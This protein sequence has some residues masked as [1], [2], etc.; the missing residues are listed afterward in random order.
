MWHRSS[1]DYL[2][3][4]NTNTECPVLLPHK[5]PGTAALIAFIGGLIGLPGIGHMYVGK[6][7]RGLQES[8]YLG[9]Y[10]LWNSCLCDIFNYISCSPITI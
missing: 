4:S 8:S 10:S 5:S 7:G 6:V 9:F 1:N 2:F 3:A